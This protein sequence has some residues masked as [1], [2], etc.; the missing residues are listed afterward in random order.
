MMSSTTAAAWATLAGQLGGQVDVFLKHSVTNSVVSYGI[1][2][3]PTDAA[4]LRNLPERGAGVFPA[5]HVPWVHVRFWVKIKERARARLFVRMH[6]VFAVHVTCTRAQ[7]ETFSCI[8]TC[9][10]A[11]ALF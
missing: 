3:P 8:C 1:T 10:V 9:C 5:G 6:V 2:L 7:L 11:V 4:C